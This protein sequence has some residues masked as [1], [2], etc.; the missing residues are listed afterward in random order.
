M[1][2]TPR[3]A[4]AKR[5]EIGLTCRKMG[6]MWLLL[7][8]LALTLLNL[9]PADGDSHKINRFNFNSGTSLARNDSEILQTS[10]CPCW[11]LL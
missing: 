1:L 7:Q 10:N 4:R 11:L 8:A 2:L 3:Q 9:R 5:F 6:W